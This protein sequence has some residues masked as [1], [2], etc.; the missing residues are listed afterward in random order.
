[1][2]SFFYVGVHGDHHK[3][4]TYGTVN[5]PEYL[6]FAKSWLM[7]TIFALNTVIVP[8]ILLFRFLVLTPLSLGF[9]SLANWVVTHASS[10]TMNIDYRRDPTPELI[11]RVRLHSLASCMLWMNIILFACCGLLP[12]RIFLVWLAIHSAV[13]FL[14]ALRTLGA[15]G[16]ENDGTPLDRNGQLLDSIDTP[17][18]FWT[19]LWAPVGLRYHAL[20]HYFPG[21]PYHNLAEGY[22]R[23]TGTLP[24]AAPYRIMTSQSLLHSLRELYVKGFGEGKGRRAS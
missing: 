3:L 24:V 14:N 12:W 10:L 19:E 11:A 21:I 18:R 5:D 9:P 1:M 13:S 15:H 6:P 2:P 22:R 23:L 16:Y 20:H 7:T 4:S 17:G 8:P